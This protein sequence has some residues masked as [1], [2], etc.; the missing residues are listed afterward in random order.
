MKRTPTKAAKHKAQRRIAQIREKIAAM[1]HVCSGT[2]VSTTTKCGK[3]NCRCATDP[4]ARHGPYHQWNRMTGG[5]L[6][7]SNISSE[8]AQQVRQA[9]RGYRTVRKL[10]RQWEEE[11]AILLGINKPRK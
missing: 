5:K 3:P 1:D 9:I 8:Q 11:T 6:I 7:H 2:V 10:L 4:S